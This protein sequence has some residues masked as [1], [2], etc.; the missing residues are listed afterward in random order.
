L[1]S[2]VEDAGDARLVCRVAR[3]ASGQSPRA[4]VGEL[5]R[6]ACP[7]WCTSPGAPS[8]RTL[9]SRTSTSQPYKERSDGHHLVASRE[10]RFRR[11]R[12]SAYGTAHARMGGCG[13]RGA[14]GSTS[15]TRWPS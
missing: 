7:R 9:R 15:R 2:L 6:P 1:S 3:D 12:P 8:S 4:R 11:C 5:D 14:P 13:C 10:P